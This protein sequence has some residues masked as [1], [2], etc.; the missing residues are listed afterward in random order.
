MDRNP[1]RPSIYAEQIRLLYQQAPSPLAANVLVASVACALLWEVADPAYLIPWLAM[2][3]VI[4]A[5][6]LGLYVSQRRASSADTSAR[7]W[8][9]AFVAGS[10][11]TG[12]AWGM[13]GL[14]LDAGWPLAH[15]LL[16]F[17]VLAG[18]SAGAI[19][20]NSNSVSAY[21]AFTLPCLLPL[22]ARLVIGGEPAYTGMGLMVM[23]YTILTL[24]IARNLNRRLAEFLRLKNEKTQLADTLSVT[25]RALEA[26]VQQRARTEQD[27]RRERDRVQNY[28]NLSQVLLIALDCDG[29]VTLANRKAC[30]T[31]GYS[32]GELLGQNWIGMCVP[33]L[34]QAATWSV[35]R[36]LLKGNSEPFSYHENVIITRDG[37]ERLVAWR[38]VVLR[39]TAG[40]I[41]GTL[42]S[43]EDITEKRQ[44]Q[45]QLKR[46]DAILEA[47]CFSATQLLSVDGWGQAID[48]VLARLGQGALVDR[49][50]L[51]E[52]HTLE[53]GTPGISQRH[54]W[55]SYR[56]TSELDNPALQNL[57]WQHAGLERWFEAL[58]SGEAIVGSVH[59]FP[60]SEQAILTPLDVR[61]ILLVPVF[62]EG[63]FWGF[64]GFDEC[65]TERRW[66]GL[67][68]DVIKSAADT[69][70][71]A[72]ARQRWQ[73][74]L[75]RLAYHDPLTGLP[76]RF[77]FR[78]RIE[79]AL[80]RAR[81]EGTLVALLFLDLDRFKNVND[82]LGHPKG[83]G[84]LERVARRLAMCVRDDDTVARL[85]GDEFTVVLENLESP[86]DAALV[87][88]KILEALSEPFTVD[89]REMFIS[90]SIGIS[91]YPRDGHDATLL[92]KHADVAMYRAKEL[93]RNDYQ[94]FTREFTATA[95]ERF[96]M[97]NSLRRALERDELLLHYQPQVSLVTG[98]IVGAEALLRWKR[99]DRVLVSPARFIPVA[100]ESG[101]ID[102]IGA[103]ALWEACRQAR[104]WLEEGLLNFRVAVNLS[105]RQIVHGDLAE[106]VKEALD[107]SGLEAR[108]LGLEITEGSVMRQA[109]VAIEAFEALKAIGVS[110]AIDDF[111]TGYS[112]MTH[113]KRFPV[114]KLKIDQSFIRDIPSDP[115]DM[116]IA[117]A[118]IALG[119]S[120]QLTVIAEGVETEE[121][122]ELM[123][124]EGCDEMQGYLSSRPLPAER[125]TKLLSENRLEDGGR[126][127]RFKTGS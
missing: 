103:W 78:A 74:K 57:S 81:R 17:F 45:E 13:F 31:L 109:D 4:A 85:G 95:L 43:G 127:D 5:G 123:R 87:A 107:G 23:L 33:P 27:L 108:Y 117:R 67:E 50:Y 53:A 83:D 120:L 29:H 82:T 75:D 32:E 88:Q 1:T 92:I 56:V 2:I 54:A 104:R 126:E 48:E 34:H 37:Q 24:T 116:A 124:T 7:R 19:L 105:G 89:G 18:M 10:F 98:A 76:N 84:L 26:Q 101:L 25:N 86:Q 72:I 39:D 94:F 118:I 49:A 59:D 77:L 113:L 16:V 52:S 3:I 55:A 11:V 44:T 71:A 111:G 115:H 125:F 106:K 38:N 8:E 21:A 93:G 99:S 96:S 42:S 122:A 41:T 62:V 100:E 112:S 9:L 110:V 60:E 51:F 22:A 12:C 97:E 102:S 73:E 90:G 30:L 36:Q 79:H 20:S 91:L 6:R 70:G 46:R 121:Q 58:Q 68:I 61:S 119:H 69:V 65:H 14:F 40:N 80:Q 114:D 28:L 63:E 66:S 35:F 15:Q 64:M 47:I